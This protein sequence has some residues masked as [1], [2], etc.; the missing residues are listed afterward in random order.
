MKIIGLSLSGGGARGLG[1]IGVIKALE[2]FGITPTIIS[3]TSAGAL[4]GAFYAAG[5]D[6]ETL[7]KIS[8]KN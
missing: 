1:H 7:I 5:Y 6:I 2:E 8:K 4:I 3:G